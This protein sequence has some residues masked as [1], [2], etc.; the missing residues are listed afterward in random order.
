M[1]P[2]HLVNEIWWQEPEAVLIENHNL[3]EE[4]YLQQLLELHFEHQKLIRE[5]SAIEIADLD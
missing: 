2:D 1:N 4:L 3:W 5:L